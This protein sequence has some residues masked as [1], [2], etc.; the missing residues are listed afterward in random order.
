[1]VVAWCNTDQLL[2]DS[3]TKPLPPEKFLHNRKRLL[4]EYDRYDCTRT[5]V[6]PNAHEQ[7]IKCIDGNIS[8]KYED[9]AH[10]CDD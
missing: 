2:A 8:L 7:L 10:N 3:L 4:G 1:M 9:K 5:I 6:L